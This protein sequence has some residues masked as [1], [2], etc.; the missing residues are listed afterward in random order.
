MQ[1]PR[2]RPH[3][4]EP[5]SMARQLRSIWLLQSGSEG[6]VCNLGRRPGE[7]RDSSVKPPPVRGSSW[8]EPA[9][10]TGLSDMF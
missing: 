4:T 9:R 1:L 6:A 2:V 8:G 3:M 5:K 10:L 7:L